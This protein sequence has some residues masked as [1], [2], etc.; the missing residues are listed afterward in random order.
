MTFDE[1]LA[2]VITLL[3]R[4]GRVSYRALQVRFALPDEH[5]EALKDELIYAQRLALD[6]EG[7]VLVWSGEA[8][9]PSALAH[10]TP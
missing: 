7:R 2:Q 9:S 4:Q 1:I 5:L 6:E 10:S 8:A 3:Q